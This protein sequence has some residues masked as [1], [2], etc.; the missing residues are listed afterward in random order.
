M[1]AAHNATTA[2]LAIPGAG[3]QM[4]HVPVLSIARSLRNP[5]KHFDQ[6][7][8][9]DLADSIKATGVH[10]PILLRPL[11]EQRIAD[12]QARAKAEKRERA[13]YELVAGERRWRACQLAGL[14]EIPAMIRPMTDAQALEAAVIENLQREDV[15]KL[16]EAEGY[17]E[18]LDVGE[19]SAEEIAGKVGK[20]RTYVFNVLKLL[21]LCEA[22]REALRE[23]KIDYSRGQ[24][25]A[26]IP[27]ESLQLQALKY[28]S[29]TNY[30]GDPM[31]FRSC[32]QYVH[33]N[34]MLKLHSAPFK[35]TDPDLVPAA[36]S[37]KACP[38]RTGANPDLFQDVSSADVCT[39]P[40]C[41][42]SKEEA[43]GIAIKRHAVERGQHII[44]GREA[45]AL[46]PNSWS[47]EVKGYLR[48]DEKQDSPLDKPLR[49]IIGKAMEAQGIQPTL[50]ANPHN[51]GELIA[52]I[53]ADQAEILLK[54]AD[55]EEAA[56]KIKAESQQDIEAAKRKAAADEKNAYEEQWRWDV[57]AEAWKQISGGTGEA[58]TE[59]VLR[60]IASGI[61]KGYSQDRAKKL[62]KLLDLGKV[63][64]AEGLLQYI[65][66]TPAPGDVLQLLLMYSDVEYRHWLD[67]ST[68]NAG[69]LLIAKDYGVDIASVKAKTKANQR[70]AKASAEA[71]AAAKASASAAPKV[72]VPLTPAAR[73]AG[74]GTKGKAQKRPAA[75][76]AGMTK[77]T[78]AETLA[79][80]AA[81][82]A[83]AGEAN[84][85]AAAAAQGDEAAPVADAQAPIHGAAAAAQNIEAAPVAAGAA[86]GLPPTSS[87]VDVDQVEAPCK[88][89]S[90]PAQTATA[91]DGQANG[92]ASQGAADKAAAIQREYGSGDLVRVKQGLK[93]STGRLRKD[94]GRV[95][96]V[97]MSSSVSILVEF[98]PG[99]A[100]RAG[101]EAEE[102]EPY[103]ADPIVCKR[104][105]VL[106]PNSAYQWQEGTVM[107]CT[108]DGWKVE[109][110][111]K[112]G[113]MA[114]TELFETI[115]LE[116]LE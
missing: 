98:G 25:I 71:K 81:A 63:A 100:Q 88:Q 105:R 76:A 79:G 57:L 106:N 78:A 83:P 26:R 14:T 29:Q 61:A 104:V 69:L 87:T 38:K 2:P 115:D 86:Q 103:K 39:D 10:Q 52:V 22:G 59:E 37:C 44:E 82:D 18:L 51:D 50:V 68:A 80:I 48:L 7:K 75:L 21:D 15:T 84:T 47:R 33:E 53:T 20:S 91:A 101:F 70:V 12:E 95:G 1:S 64:P 3:P 4:L 99:A 65:A 24:L 66:D 27:D 55:N 32:S 31:G 90:A 116:S 54:A 92:D 97:R 36:G 94:C 13:H 110:P 107:A 46:M 67:Q 5:R 6:V 41:Y 43:H 60:Y 111:A 17:R 73:A 16:E 56:A 62:C 9:E 34:F 19:T 113:A 74:S 30:S 108:A 77:A 40:K 28:C 42:R 8:L 109:F 49:K 112:R 72:D 96:V 58:P 11:P 85:G 35:M 114:K 23:G 102:I 93:G 45:K 89:Q